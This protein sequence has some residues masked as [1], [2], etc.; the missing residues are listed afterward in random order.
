M[1]WC[2]YC[3]KLNHYEGGLF[4]YSDDMVRSV[5]WVCCPKR[6]GVDIAGRKM[7]FD[8]LERRAEQLKQFD[9]IAASIPE[10]SD[11]VNA[12]AAMKAVR[13]CADFR[14]HFRAACPSLYEFIAGAVLHDEGQLVWDEELADYSGNSVRR[15]RI[16][17]RGNIAGALIMTPSLDLPS[18]LDRVRAELG[19]LLEFYA[20]K[21][22]DVISSDRFKAHARR[23]ARV[24]EDVEVIQNATAALPEF[25]TLANRQAMTYVR[26]LSMA[27]KS[28][29]V[30]EK[31]IRWFP[32]DG[33]EP[34]EITMPSSYA[35]P[36]F[37]LLER[38]RRYT[39]S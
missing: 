31:G 26:N 24:L 18:L 36:K 16:K 28:Y 15:K 8:S 33:R 13:Q 11:E 25:F 32:M 12:S 22:T 5:G 37:R 34:V 19:E 1:I 29:E 7:E 35:A 38:L 23:L 14:A 9:L 39:R 21:D 30:S 3:Q 6:L 10:L 17:K 4:K 20:I 27:A 2:C